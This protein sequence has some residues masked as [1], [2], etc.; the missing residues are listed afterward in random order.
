MSLYKLPL[1]RKKEYLGLNSL[2]VWYEDSSKESEKIFGISNVPSEFCAGKNVIKISGTD[3]LEYLTEVDIEILDSTGSP[4]YWEIPDYVDFAKRRSIIVWIYPETPTGLGSITLTGNLKNSDVPP[5]WQDRTNV[6]WHYDISIDSTSPNKDEIAFGFKPAISIEEKFKTVS[7]PSFEAGS[8]IPFSEILTDVKYRSEKISQGPIDNVETYEDAAKKYRDSTSDKNIWTTWNENSITTD[9][10]LK[11]IGNLDRNFSEAQYYSPL[12]KR[13]N[14]AKLKASSGGATLTLSSDLFLPEMEGGKINIDLATITNGTLSPVSQKSGAT[15][16]GTQITKIVQVINSSTVRVED[17]IKDSLGNALISGD[18]GQ[19]TVEYTP[20]PTSYIRSDKYQNFA[21]VRMSDVNPVSGD[22]YKIKLYSRNQESQDNKFELVTDRILQPTNLLIDRDVEIENLEIGVLPTGSLVSSYWSASAHPNGTQPAASG[23][24]ATFD[25]R[26]IKRGISVSSSQANSTIDTGFAKLQPVSGSSIFSINTY[27][28]SSYI[29]EFDVFGETIKGNFETDGVAYIC[30]SGSSIQDRPR[31]NE[32]KKM[33]N[34]VGFKGQVLHKISIND[35]TKTKN[36]KLL[37]DDSALT[38][39][40]DDD[41]TLTPIIIMK[42]GKW[43]FGELRLKPYSEA[44]FT[45]SHLEFDLP[46]PPTF[47]ST[48][49]DFK[50]EF[51]DYLGNVSKEIAYVNNISFTNGNQVFQQGDKNINIGKQTFGTDLQSGIVIETAETP[52]SS[53][54]FGTAIRSAGFKSYE[55]A[56]A[57]TAPAGWMFNSGSVSGSNEKGATFELA[58]P[59]ASFRFSSDPTDPN[60]GL[61][62]V[63]T[64]IESNTIIISGSS[65]GLTSSFWTGSGDYINREGDVKVTGSLE[66]SQSIYAQEAFVHNKTW[67]GFDSGMVFVVGSTPT[68]QVGLHYQKLGDMMTLKGNVTAQVSGATRVNILGGAS[69]GKKTAEFN[70]AQSGYIDFTE[71]AAVSGSTF[72]GSFAGDGSGLTGV[73]GGGSAFPFTGSA[74][75]TG[76]LAI[77]G[78]FF[79]QPEPGAFVEI[80]GGFAIGDLGLGTVGFYHSPNFNYTTLGTGTGYNSIT[81]GEAGEG[82]N[83]EGINLKAGGTVKRITIKS[84]TSSTPPIGSLEIQSVDLIVSSSHVSSSVMSA[85]VFSGSFVGDG[86][87]L[88]GVTG[89]G[90]ASFPYTGSA[91]FSGSVDITGSFEITG[92]AGNNLNFKVEHPDGYMMMRSGTG[93]FQ[94]AKWAQAYYDDQE[95]AVYGIRLRGDSA[96]LESNDGYNGQDYSFLSAT[97][98]A[99]ISSSDD[100]GLSSLIQAPSIK[101]VPESMGGPLIQA[102]GSFRLSGSLGIAS[103]SYAKANDGDGITVALSSSNAKYS[104]TSA[105]TPN[106]AVFL[107]EH[108]QGPGEFEGSGSSIFIISSA[109]YSSPGVSTKNAVTQLTSISAKNNTHAAHF[110]VGTR[111]QAGNVTEK[112]RVESEG[113]VSVGGQFVASGSMQIA[114]A[115]GSTHKSYDMSGYQKSSWSQSGGDAIVYNDGYIELYFDDAASDDFEGEI[116]T[117]PTTGEV[118]CTINNEGSYTYLDRQVSDGRF[119]FDSSLGN[120]EIL[121]IHMRAPLDTDYPWYKITVIS[122]N[123][124]S[125]SNVTMIVERYG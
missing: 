123:S 122:A 119:V 39:Q 55:E 65:T 14:K 116:I 66:V 25:S 47:D 98:I 32:E 6:K 91:T 75:I 41:G 80:S 7:R 106:A 67:G 64:S 102:T 104:S 92:S 73:S 40:P 13:V 125:G 48:T 19:V 54:T 3:S 62:I 82:A 101:L 44:G 79:A 112:L 51:T 26:N 84:G 58:A 111:N 109:Q 9:K 88:T 17:T 76:G 86:S 97:Q 59:S 96:I 5:E 113:K 120:D 90:G 34:D 108:G 27:S 89:G 95:T 42:G 16:S 118:H 124:T 1:R 2:P 28:S 94:W 61:Q 114:Q 31:N 33:F 68:T 23:V 77:T 103:G 105:M 87:G 20:S 72:S 100:G 36:G 85:S 21:R 60:E 24:S 8:N 93:E 63:A 81:M 121:T 35:I 53:S 56:I 43:A 115:S 46:V 52:Q 117:N 29:F 71:F 49:M 99:V 10:G 78:S 15:L 50:V 45:P 110:T 83:N 12:V 38:F 57:G 70:F 18:I 4:V 74:Q 30:L 37:I 11:S 69:T 107:T 22:I